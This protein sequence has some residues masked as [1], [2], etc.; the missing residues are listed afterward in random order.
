MAALRARSC[1]RCRLGLAGA[2][3]VVLDVVDAVAEAAGGE[4]GGG[5]GAAEVVVVA[6]A[7]A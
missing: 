4:D 3:P 1:G 2:V 6:V 7:G 5:G